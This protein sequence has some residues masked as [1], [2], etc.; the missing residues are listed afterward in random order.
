MKRKKTVCIISVVLLLVLFIIWLLC[1]A[2]I[3]NNTERIT[4][5]VYETAS[6]LGG[7]EYFSLNMGYDGVLSENDYCTIAAE[8]SGILD[9]VP[10]HCQWD[11]DIK[12][13]HTISYGIGASTYIHD[14]CKISVS[15]GSIYT[16]YDRHIRIDWKR[17]TDKHRYEAANT[18]EYIV[19]P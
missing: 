6:A 18:Y 7:Y 14:S 17:N 11:W 16:G 3:S 5:S 13:I 9:E 2:R 19:F 8:I 4:N 12:S 10:E 15:D 1:N